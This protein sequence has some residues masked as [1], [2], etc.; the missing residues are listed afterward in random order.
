[1]SFLLP[2]YPIPCAWRT[3]S[4]INIFSN[5]R[6]MRLCVS[7]EDSE[8]L[9]QKLDFTDT[10]KTRAADL[11]GSCPMDPQLNIRFGDVFGLQWTLER[12]FGVNLGQ[13]KESPFSDFAISSNVQ[14]LPSNW[15]FFDFSLGFVGSSC[16]SPRP[17]ISRRSFLVRHGDR[18]RIFVLEQS[19]KAST[20]GV[21]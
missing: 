9:K 8:D 11:P 21:Y 10:W 12:H 5:I 18:H 14:L 2:L 3:V 19:M 20:F 16:V 4:R 13:G 15:H 17:V 7:H 1:M 6:S